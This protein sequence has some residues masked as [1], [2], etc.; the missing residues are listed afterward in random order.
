MPEGTLGRIQ[1]SNL[2]K[3]KKLM[4]LGGS[5]TA[6]SAAAPAPVTAQVEETL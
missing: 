1:A 2:R 5:A 6:G 3:P 4:S